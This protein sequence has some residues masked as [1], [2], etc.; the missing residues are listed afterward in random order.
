[1]HNRS[2]PVAN[3]AY[4][5]WLDSPKPGFSGEVVAEISL[6]SKLRIIVEICAT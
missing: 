4:K 5:L 6:K 3:T 2:K 1:M